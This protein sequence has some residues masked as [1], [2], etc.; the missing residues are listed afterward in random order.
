MLQSDIRFRVGIAGWKTKTKRSVYSSKINLEN[1]EAD[2]NLWLFHPKA[3]QVPTHLS[4]VLRNV[5]WERSEGKVVT[6][7][8]MRNCD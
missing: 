3:R 1:N 8:S 5:A 2:W 4:Q 6:P 7:H